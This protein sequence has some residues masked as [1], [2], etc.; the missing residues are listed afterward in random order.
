MNTPSVA[1]IAQAFPECAQEI[2]NL[3]SGKTKT[4][5]YE[6][7]KSLIQLCYTS[8]DYQQRIMT[9][10]NEITKQHGFEYVRHCSDDLKSFEYIN[11]GDTYN[12]TLIMYN[13]GK[14]VVSSVGDIVEMGGYD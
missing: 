3:I 8:P 6:S 14:I 10:I 7:V 4:R 5:Q 12:K 9:A 11:T 1:T 2:K 13:S